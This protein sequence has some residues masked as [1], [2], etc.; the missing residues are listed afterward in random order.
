[1]KIWNRLLCLLLTTTL[2]ACST[3]N[4]PVQATRAAW[5]PEQ[6]QVRIN[7]QSIDTDTQRLSLVIPGEGRLLADRIAVHTL[8]DGT[9]AWH[10]T[11]IA[12]SAAPA[13]NGS[14][15]AALNSII[16]IRS[17]NRVSGIIRRD[18]QAYSLL[19]SGDATVLSKIDAAKLPPEHDP[20]IPSG[21]MLGPRQHVAIAPYQPG[22]A[23]IRVLVVA[24]RQADEASE[25]LRAMAHLA[26][27]ESNQ[28]FDESGI[29]L[30]LELAD[31]FPLD[32][33]QSF[34]PNWD[35][36]R[37]MKIDDGYMD[38]VHDMRDT[39]KADVVVLLRDNANTSCGFAGEIGASAET[40]F[41]V[42]NVR[43]IGVG[44]FTFAH[45]IGHLLGG[46]HDN[47]SGPFAYGHGYAHEPA[48]GPKLYTVMTAF[49]L[50]T[51]RLPYWSDPQREVD[52]IR[53]GDKDTADN[54]RLLE[55]RKGIVA[56]FR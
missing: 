8:P 34:S 39:L 18:G 45:E 33:E 50:D 12:E 51:V 26:I 36:D 55:E 21:A 47:A 42:V 53:L 40:A 28:T 7:P 6:W 23:T 54:H 2:A 27:E 56:G 5:I 4:P 22:H 31:V 29:D 24:S 19:P 44:R 30:S 17:S 48:D 20:S 25:D 9:I 13:A 15:K 37:L 46:A 3:I 10:G 1:M 32:Y 41:T 35:L 49:R 11:L 52:G 16:L 14:L 43:C 38:E